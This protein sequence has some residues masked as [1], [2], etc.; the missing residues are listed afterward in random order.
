MEAL[1][2]SG[3]A[4]M[5]EEIEFCRECGMEFADGVEDTCPLC[6]YEL[7]LEEDEDD[8]V[9]VVGKQ[10][11]DG[12]LCAE[13]GKW[14]DNEDEWFWDY[15]IDFDGPDWLNLD[16]VW[17][18][19][20]IL[21]R[22][23]KDNPEFAAS[24]LEPD[25]YLIWK[26]ALDVGIDL[27]PKL[28][29]IEISNAIRRL[30]YSDREKIIDW[31]N[32][33]CSIDDAEEWTM[34]FDEVEEALEWRDA[35]FNPEEA[36]D[37]TDWECTPTEAAEARDSGDGY[38]PHLDFKKFGFGFKDAVFLNN[39][40]FE[41]YEDEGSECYIGTW[42]PSGLSL[43]EI[44]NLRTELNDKH[45]LFENLHRQSQPRLKY[46]E[47]TYDFW[48]A[49]PVQFEELRKTGL[50]INSSNLEKYW[51]LK[52]KEILK[53][54]DAGGAPGVAAEA[55]RQGASVGKLGI[56]ERLIE[57]GAA[58]STATVLAKRGFLLKHLKQ[59]EKKKD[60]GSTFEWIARVLE[61]D[62]TIQ[63]DEALVWLDA[64]ARVSE[65]KMWRQH[66]FSA[67]EATKWA[68]EGFSPEV[69]KRWRDAGASSPVVAKRRQDAGLNP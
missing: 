42:L 51:G 26:E 43:P 32:S 64:E 8:N 30:R 37:W 41:P 12:E 44:V 57:L 19:D 58:S 21:K 53:V 9:F 67:Q 29:D 63:V 39:Q 17:C 5:D 36:R 28:F 50:M 16:D 34:L 18:F 31:L 47:R 46:E 38:R 13:C 56:I 55:I 66:G 14:Y 10:L 24:G 11:V 48:E 59:I 49:L 61:S 6:G 3:A 68:N 15:W 20:C 69:A 65:V 54:I 2:I 35:G 4:A 52:T 45:E 7:G 25:T 33:D 1:T 22:F 62:G 23:K 40:D 60:L 27:G